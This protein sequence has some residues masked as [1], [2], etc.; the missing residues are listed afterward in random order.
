MK[1]KKLVAMLFVFGLF[2]GGCSDKSSSPTDS[3][4]K[5]PP[6]TTTEE[7]ERNSKISGKVADG[8]IKNATVF[9]DLDGDKVYDEGEPMTTTDTLGGYELKVS[10]DEIGSYAIV[11]LVTDKSRDLDDTTRAIKPYTMTAP[12]PSVSS[13][14]I[15]V[16]PITTMIQNKMEKN[17][18]L[19]REEAELQTR[20]EIGA[21]VSL[22]EDYVENGG[23]VDYKAVHRV[24]QLV[25]RTMEKITDILGDKVDDNQKSALTSLV[26]T[27]VADVIDEIKLKAIDDANFD[28]ESGLIK[29]DVLESVDGDDNVVSVD[30]VNNIEGVLERENLAI[31]K[32]TKSFKDIVDNGGSYSFYLE[33]ENNEKYLRVALHTVDGDGNFVEAKSDYKNS[34]WSDFENREFSEAHYIDG[35][36]KKITPTASFTSDGSLE[37]KYG[38]DYLFTVSSQEVDLS[39]KKIRNY[40]ESGLELTDEDATFESG[41]KGHSLIFSEKALESYSSF[42]LDGDYVREGEIVKWDNE[43]FSSLESFLNKFVAEDADNFDEN[44]PWFKIGKLTDGEDYRDYIV[45]QVKNKEEK[46]LY[47]ARRIGWGGYSDGGERFIPIKEQT[48]TYKIENNKFISFNIPDFKGVMDHKC[49]YFESDLTEGGKTVVVQGR[50]YEAGQTY[51]QKQSDGDQTDFNKTAIDNIKAAIDYD[52]TLK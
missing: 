24:A 21:E 30:V 52:E 10:D 13:E 39:G 37:L 49:C 47:I 16:S 26:V 27:L 50:S 34:S 12:P 32:E 23:A 4:K 41:A 35:E 46:T 45:A 43:S 44:K 29:S 5:D 6:P 51:Y 3:K 48:A 36:I 14:N 25:A 19:S 11:V 38:D 22:F 2:M 7:V 28:T 42:D 31:N 20:S 33:S 9:L 18:E 8:Y 17:K 1:L 15:F 40:I